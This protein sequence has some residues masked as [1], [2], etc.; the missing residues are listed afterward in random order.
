M[1]E[2]NLF[3][4]VSPAYHGVGTVLRETMWRMIY[5]VL[6]FIAAEAFLFFGKSQLGRYPQ[7]E[8]VFDISNYV[9][10]LICGTYTLIFVIIETIADLGFSLR[11]HIQALKLQNKQLHDNL[12]Q[13]EIKLNTFVYALKT[14]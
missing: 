5:I 7:F 10:I 14:D 4:D 3:I 1:E 12:H 6:F 2:Y 8:A 9:V 13:A 11:Y